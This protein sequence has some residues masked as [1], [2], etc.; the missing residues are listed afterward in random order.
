M[1]SFRTLGVFLSLGAAA[2][3]SAA[4]TAAPRVTEREIDAH[5][6]F[7]SL[8]LLEGRGA[9]TRGGRLAAEYI[10]SQLQA[11]G[12]EPGVNGSYFQPV[13]VNVVGAD[14]SMLRV[15]ASGR[16]S[17]NFRYP[18]DVVV[19]AGSDV[20]KSEAKGEL[21]FVGY[22][23]TAPEFNWDDF[24]GVDVRGKVLMVLVNDPPALASE[25]KLFGGR[26]M[27]YYGRWTYKFEEAERRGAA[28]MLIVHTT[29]AAGYPWQTVSGSWAKD[30]RIVSRS[31]GQPPPVGFRGWITDSVAGKLLK[32]AGLDLAQLRGQAATRAFRPV[33]TGIMIDAQFRNRVARLQGQNV[34]GVLRG[35]DEKLRDEYVVYSAH[36]DHLGIGPAVNGDSIYNGAAD[37]ASGVA[38]ILAVARLAAAFPRTKRSQLFVFVDLE[39]SGLLGSDYF[40]RNPTVPV[41]SMI[42]NLNVDGGGRSY[43]GRFRTLDTRS[44]DTKSTLGPLLSRFVA[45]QSLRILPEAHPE[46]GYFYRSDHFSFAKVGV[47]AISIGE[48]DDIVGKPAGFGQKRDADYLA[49]RY[50]QPSDEYRADFDYSGAVQ[51]TEIVARFGASLA[52]SASVPQWNPDAEFRSPKK[53]QA[54]AGR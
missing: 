46:R 10:A 9:A 42:A 8:D 49:K 7:L 3:P 16:A 14:R 36:Y 20:E 35:R 21:V 15:T 32:D 45:A 24:K 2:V 28:G 31:P 39:E 5:V 50:H 34:V 22:G 23:A 11:Y 37:N 26:A 27:T 48:G 40:A 43:N 4:Q 54:G 13:P 19:W 29:E 41:A 30:Q 6:R 1:K 44:G 47:P 33:S 12:V 52:N 25:P 18:E 38:E 17:M 53:T 51:L